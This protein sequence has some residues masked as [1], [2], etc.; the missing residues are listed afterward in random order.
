MVTKLYTN[1]KNIKMQTL[2]NAN[3]EGYTSLTQIV[4]K[5]SGATIE[6]PL[7]IDDEEHGLVHFLT[8]DTDFDEVGTYY[9][10]I[11]LIFFNAEFLSDTI[12]FI[13]NESFS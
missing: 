9:T 11:K 2:L 10:Q 1:Q 13:V 12:S 4:K 3:L 7:D 6:K 8:N 5:P